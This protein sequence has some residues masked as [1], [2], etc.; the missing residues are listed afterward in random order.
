MLVVA[1]PVLL[2]FLL[3]VTQEPAAGTGGAGA[4]N[5]GSGLAAGSVPAED[6][7]ALADAGAECGAVSAPLLAAQVDAESSFNPRAVSAQGAEGIA[8]FLPSTWAT[9]GRD[10]SGD[11]QADVWNVEDAIGSQAAYMCHI[12]DLI[13]A[14]M[15]KGQVRGDLTRLMLAGYNVGEYAVIAAGGMPAG[16]AERYAAKITA[17]V[18]RYAAITDDGSGTG[19]GSSLAAAAVV[20]AR[21]KLGSPYVFGAT[22]PAAYD[23]SGYIEYAY[24]AASGGR[25]D[26]G[27]LTYDQ[28]ASPYAHMVPLDALQ[29]GDLVFIHVPGDAQGGWN[30]V[31]MFIGNNQLVEE[32]RPGEVAR[33][34]PMSEYA[35][36][37]ETARRIVDP[38]AGEATS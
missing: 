1:V 3:L 21:A 7:Q 15:D 18:P 13:Q 23:C 19:D 16:G 11:G 34:M 32:P 9:W 37:S 20:A 28:V 26:I 27:R 4:G 33:I 29:P 25:I 35:G 30:H 14:A 2:I 24:R 36:Y 38:K 5:G 8:Q 31:V 22:G 6:V 10:Y 17:L 12:A